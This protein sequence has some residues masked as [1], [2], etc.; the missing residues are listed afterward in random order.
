MKNKTQKSKPLIE[1]KT[2]SLI[3]E[4]NGLMPTTPPKPRPKG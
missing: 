1:G 3:K 4:Y 2:K